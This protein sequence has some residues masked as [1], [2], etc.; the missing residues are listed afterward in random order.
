MLHLMLTVPEV[1]E[2]LGRSPETVRRWIRAGKLRASKVGT[3]HV[4]SEEDLE[5]WVTTPSRVAEP[6]TPY[7]SGPAVMRP[8]PDLLDRISIDPEVIGGKPAIRGTRIGVGLVLEILA[9]GWP[10]AEILEAYPHL[11]PD[12]VR[13]CLAY[14]AHVVD[15]ESLPLRRS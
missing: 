12:D 13:A 5:A 15:V 3:Q 7:A 2:R 8:F 11:T 1:A 14:A 9:S 4:V 10:E 6:R